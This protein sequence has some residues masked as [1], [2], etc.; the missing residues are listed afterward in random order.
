MAAAAAQALPQGLEPGRIRPWAAQP[1]LVQGGLETLGPHRLEQVIHRIQLESLDRVVVVGGGE[2]HR[3]H[4]LQPRQMPG[5]LQPVHAR[6]VDVGQNHVHRLSGM[7]LQPFQG[8]Q[9]IFRLAQDP[10]RTDRGQILQQG[11]QADPG[12]GFVIDEQQ[13]QGLG[14]LQ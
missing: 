9:A 6:H 2:D 14:F 5:Q 8:R 4:L 11:A 3:R 10:G 7:V 13:V 12:Q 1:G